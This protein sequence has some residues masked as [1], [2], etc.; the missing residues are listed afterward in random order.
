MTES[1]PQKKISLNF[2]TKADA[3]VKEIAAATV[4]T[5]SATDLKQH[6]LRQMNRMD[7]ENIQ[8]QGVIQ[9]ANACFEAICYGLEDIHRAVSDL[10]RS[11]RASWLN[12]LLGASVVTQAKIDKV[13]GLLPTCEKYSLKL[14]EQSARMGEKLREKQALDE[15]IYAQ[16]EQVRGDEGWKIRHGMQQLREKSE[17]SARNLG[18]VVSSFNDLAKQCLALQ[19]KGTKTVQRQQAVLQVKP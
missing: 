19:D 3:S 18:H 8:F 5:D 7:R 11:R 9:E 4:G 13:S 2:K 12:W 16:A 1:A 10:E 6:L 15:E 14:E 17:G